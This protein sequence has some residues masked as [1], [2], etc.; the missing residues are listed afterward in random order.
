MRFLVVEDNPR[1]ADLLKRVL[2][3]E[4][5]EVDIAH[6][7]NKGIE[8]AL[9]NGYDGIILDVMLPDRSGVDVCRELRRKGQ[10]TPI[11]MLTALSSTDQKVDGLDAGAD[12][13]LTKPFELD[14]LLARVRSLLRR[15]EASEGA[16]LRH[17]DLELNLATRVATRGGRKIGLTA[18]EYAL[19][20]F[21]LRNTNRV[22]SRSRIGERVWGM[23]FEE[24][25]NVIEVY[26]SRLRQKIEKGADVP[27][28][29]TVIGMG[30]ILSEEGPP[31][32]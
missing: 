5:Y 26:V 22:L 15:S 24:S 9:T 31:A 32:A 21:F 6:A 14:E 17:S 13:Y 20:E 30:Y 4:A 28:M 10:T 19:L 16:V 12:D 7:G 25:S 11:L 27:L 8:M 3:D 2:S 1:V 18:K 29:H 23:D